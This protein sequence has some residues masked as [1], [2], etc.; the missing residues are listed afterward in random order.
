[1]P[2]PSDAL[3]VAFP[4]LGETIG[5]VIKSGDTLKDTFL[6]LAS[7][8]A[9]FVEAIAPSVVRD[10][11]QAMRDLQATIGSA[12]IAPMQIFGSVVREVSG[13][14]L[15]LMQ[16]LEPVFKTLADAIGNLVTGGLRVL[17]SV[18][19]VLAPIFQILADATA[20]Y[21]GILNDVSGIFTALV[22]TLGTIIGSLLGT[23]VSGFKET[24]KQLADIVRQVIK[25]FLTLVATLMVA[26]GAADEV[27]LFAATLDKEARD[28]DGR[29]MGLKAAGTNPTISDVASLNKQ[30]Q[31]AAF[32]AAGG[33][34]AREKS[35]T[36]W[37]REIA[38]AVKDVAATKKSFGDALRDWWTV[39]V[40]GGAGILG[41]VLR[42]VD[43]LQAK[44]TA[45]F[46]RFPA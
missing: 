31:L 33:G 9:P 21:Y 17:V 10:F 16:K 23:D 6:L 19:E 32:T 13:I 45:F 24:F 37:L 5:A 28:R 20:A 30:Q 1:M 39:E 43:G 42:F 35:D 46:G 36:E 11:N 15:P 26:A 29:A 22:K 25:A 4:L 44:I 38:T 41:R 2:S 3:A 40:V 34:A 8:I 12:L 27:K 18:L 7:T 14:L